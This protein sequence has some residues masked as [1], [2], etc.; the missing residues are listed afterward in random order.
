MEIEPGAK[1]GETLQTDGAAD[2]YVRSAYVVDSPHADPG[3]E[4]AFL[5]NLRPSKPVLDLVG[6]LPEPFDIALHIRMSTG[7]DFDHLPHESPANWPED[8]HQEMTDWRADSNVRHFVTRLDRLVATGQAG[9][10]FAA[11]DLAESYVVLTE[12]YGQRVQMLARDL[13]DRSPRQ[14]Q[15]AL[16]D[17]IL[18]T[19]AP[20]FLASTG[21]SFS[22]MAQRLARP[23]RKL[24]R[25]GVEF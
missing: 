8:R 25:S 11:A 3:A 10:I 1:F 5:R 17:L 23:G 13:Y 6:A 12:R 2:V 9:R 18:L 4:T 15:Y 21:S 22:D 16:A 20:L 24:E 7:P 14:L 19:R